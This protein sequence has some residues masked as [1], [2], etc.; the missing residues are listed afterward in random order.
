MLR[1]DELDKSDSR[2]DPGEPMARLRKLET[3]RD[4]TVEGVPARDPV[5]S[6]ADPVLRTKDVS[7]ETNPYHNVS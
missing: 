5:A 1:N 4:E 3:P 2:V 6:A 7:P